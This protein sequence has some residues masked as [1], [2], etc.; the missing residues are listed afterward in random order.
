MTNKEIIIEEIMGELK[1]TII[2]GE[3][4]YGGNEKDIEQFTDNLLSKLQVLDRDNVKKLV[5]DC[6]EYDDFYVPETGDEGYTLYATFEKIEKVVDQICQLIPEQGEV[7]VEG[8]VRYDLHKYF[9]YIGHKELTEIS[10][11]LSEK[12]EDFKDEKIQL[13]I[14]KCKEGK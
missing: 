6:F 7:I 14:H 4:W 3:Y 2:D 11:F 1:T 5:E 12:L 13:I 10:E 8:K 9:V